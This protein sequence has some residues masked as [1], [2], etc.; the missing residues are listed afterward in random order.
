MVIRDGDLSRAPV[1]P[2][3]NDAPLVV[4][5]DR[6]PALPG[7]AERLQAVAGRNREIA[8]P[9][10]AVELEKFSQG[11]PGNGCETPVL[12]VVEKFPGVPIGEGLDH[13]ACRE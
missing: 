10:G 5:A 8:Q 3:K 2:T 6:M 12:F 1:C 13:D 9:A 7:T 11:N 4:D